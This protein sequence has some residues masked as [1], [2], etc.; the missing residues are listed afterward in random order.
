L[1]SHG[2]LF[3]QLQQDS[4]QGH[5]NEKASEP[6]FPG[7]TIKSGRK[8]GF[9]ARKTP[10]KHHGIT[11]RR[12]FKLSK[13]NRV[14]GLV[15]PP[16]RVRQEA[17]VNSGE[18]AV[19]TNSIISSFLHG[20]R[21]NS[22][23]HI[24]SFGIMEKVNLV[25]ANSREATATLEPDNPFIDRETSDISIKKR[26]E[27]SVSFPGQ[28]VEAPRLEGKKLTKGVGELF[29]HHILSGPLYLPNQSSTP[30]KRA[31]LRTTHGS[32]R[33][34]RNIIMDTDSSPTTSSSSFAGSSWR[35]HLSASEGENGSVAVP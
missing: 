24:G 1:D 9:K 25:Q 27:V 11:N 3:S 5:F 20:D 2:D 23:P 28:L 26:V 4:T 32:N 12:S 6:T 14:M 8:V 16:R 21:F 29:Y 17:P 7:R 33:S 15:L 35:A 30:A 19:A 18:V 22:S 10:K 34:R 13:P 31:G